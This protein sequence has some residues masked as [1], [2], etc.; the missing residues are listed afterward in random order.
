M[1]NEPT[2]KLSLKE[3][4]ALKQK[5]AEQQKTQE[6]QPQPPTQTQPEQNQ[7]STSLTQE[8]T[9]PLSKADPFANMTDEEKKAEKKRIR[10][11]K[12][13]QKQK[14]KNKNYD[15]N[16]D[17]SKTKQK[18]ETTKK[19][20]M[21]T[22]SKQQNKD[23]PK[24]KLTEE[25]QKQYNIAQF[26][27]MKQR[28]QQMQYQAQVPPMPYQQQQQ[29]LAQVRHLPYQQ[30]QQF[31]A[32]VQH[33]WIIQSQSQRM[34]SGYNQGGNHHQV[35]NFNPAY[36]S[37]RHISGGYKKQGYNRGR[38]H[39][40]HKRG[41]FDDDERSQ[42]SEYTRKDVDGDKVQNINIEEPGNDEKKVNPKEII[43]SL[44]TVNKEKNKE[45][46]V[47]TVE[48]KVEE[49]KKED[50]KVV[51][52]PKK[53][54]Q[55]KEKEVVK[56]QEVKKEPEVKPVK[57]EEP[58]KVE[59][60][61]EEQPKKE[62][63]VE[64][65]KEE[66]KQPVQKEEVKPKE[67]EPVK[68]EQKKEQ[69][70]QKE[71]PQEKKEEP[72]QPEEQ[73]EEQTEEKQHLL[74]QP[75]S[76][77]YSHT[78]ILNFL[79]NYT[80]ELPDHYQHLQRTVEE[81]EV[82]PPKKRKN[83]NKDRG[84]HRHKHNDRLDVSKPSKY[85]S[86]KHHDRHDRHHRH[87]DRD[88][89][90]DQ[91]NTETL[92][93]QQVSEEYL[94]QMKKIKNNADT[95]MANK[96]DDDET[97]VNFKKIKGLLNKLTAD[98]YDKIAAQILE[99]ND[100]QE[101]MKKLIELLVK[102][103]WNEPMY[104]KL[105]AKLVNTLYKNKF[106]WDKA[107]KYK[108]VKT[109][110][111]GKVEDAYTRGFDAYYQL[112]KKIHDDDKM[113][114]KEKFEQLF[115]QKKLLLGNINFICELFFF[116]ILN[117]KL[118]KLIILYGIGR[119]TKEYIRVENTKDKFTI[120]E[121]YLEALIKFF[122][123]AGKQIEETEE[124]EMKKNKT[125]VGKTEEYLL[126]KLEGMIEECEDNTHIFV[127]KDQLDKFK[128]LASITF[129]FFEFL[130]YIKKENISQRMISLIENLFEY[131]N[132][133]WTLII[134][135]VK[136]AKSKREV[137]LAVEKERE[138]ERGRDRYRE[139]E[140]YEDEYRSDAFQKKKGGRKGG[141]RDRDRGDRR[142]KMSELRDYDDYN[143]VEVEDEY[144]P[145]DPVAPSLSVEKITEKLKDFFKEHKDDLTTKKFYSYMDDMSGA[146][147]EDLLVVFFVLFSERKK[148]IVNTIA[149]YPFYL[150]EEKRITK[151]K[152]VDCIDKANRKLYLLF[153]DMPLL[154][155]FMSMYIC[156]LTDMGVNV[157]NKL[158]WKA[159]DGADIEEWIY[160]GKQ[161]LNSVKK[162]FEKNDKGKDVEKKIAE[163]KAYLESLEE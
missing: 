13:K 141:N 128:T 87:R 74:E 92:Q 104:T 129:V 53:V 118:F 145:K 16:P 99:L 91:D 134:R 161:F 158:T 111:L 28:Q 132:T 51:K 105:Y 120:K 42:G 109:L 93:R 119:F 52:E 31:M 17:K 133:G 56:K 58:K 5:K 38:P 112:T 29:Y 96:K 159:D 95:W 40:P 138:Q 108:T 35:N 70:Q 154:L 47:E 100:S 73:T 6:T 83:Y 148:F 75:A 49:K 116:K 151:E 48:K 143:E 34:I 22:V 88:R 9:N 68:Q 55:V 113:E 10:M 162:E 153:C 46:K 36:N 80:A 89:D 136:A 147:V 123:N 67:E 7:P 98:N 32:Q 106:K 103:A 72:Q 71:Q 69:P 84:G 82:P 30:Q 121:D 25:E 94:I 114:A 107:N 115:K 97:T 126:N 8:V 33:S 19:K 127:E 11:E 78:Y 146:A 130:E 37:N 23:T 124:K 140:R 4:M 102:K 65:P 77:V 142:N 156:K 54:E 50:V 155:S 59:K 150:I 131:R 44:Y 3:R 152:V 81:Q 14:L 149:D 21:S 15:F 62:K 137:Q 39:A 86:R 20:K 135:K 110:V 64:Q 157:L 117:F 41:R 125:E 24:V 27:Q 60:K 160:Y 57:K 1:D 63:K 101:V 76:L 90:R 66:V 18:E 139:Y 45:E 26:K 144:V 122:E 43:D 85:G 61:K 163:I 12:L 79:E 2:K